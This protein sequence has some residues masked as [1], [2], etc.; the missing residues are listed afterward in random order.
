MST[1][2]IALLVPIVLLV[3]ALPSECP[4]AD[5]APVAAREGEDRVQRSEGDRTGPP[6][7]KNPGNDAIDRRVL[8]LL[9]RSV[10]LDVVS[11]EDT[12][13]SAPFDTSKYTR[14][15]I[16]ATSMSSDGRICCAVGWQ[17]TARDEFLE[18]EPTTCSSF[19]SVLG[20]DP[21]PRPQYARGYRGPYMAEVAGL[22]AQ[23]VCRIQP[24]LDPT[25]PGEPPQASGALT[26]VKVLLRE[27]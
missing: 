15:G 25:V 12:W 17:F 1:K 22:R 19:Y 8:D 10:V 11:G 26:D 5:A 14:V 6:S 23:V 7:D 2:I 18:S 9:D 3:G 20:D 16:R 13:R 24:T 4:A 21:M 27:R